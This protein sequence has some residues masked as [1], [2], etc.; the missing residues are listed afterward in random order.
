MAFSGGGDSVALLHLLRASGLRDLGAV[1]VHHGL[2]AVAD[3]WVRH[4]RKL[5]RAMDVPLRVLRV[6]VRPEGE[7][8]EAAARAARLAAFAALLKPGDVLATA[9]HRDDQAETILFRALRGT[10]IAGLGG[11]REC[12][13]LGQGTLWRPLL[14]VPRSQ[15]RAYAETQ[16][17]EWVDDPHNRDSRYA[18]AFLRQDVFPLLARHFPAAHDSLARLGRHAQ[19]A[20]GLLAQLAQEDAQRLEDRGGLTIPGLLRLDA[21]RRR[22]LLYH[23]WRAL[24]LQVPDADWFEKLERE[25]LAARPDADPA[26]AQGEG[27]ARRY[28][29]RLYLMR[30]LAPAPGRGT[31]K[32]WPRRKRSELP[33]GCGTLSCN[34]VPGTDVNVRFAVGGAHLRPA[35]SAHRRTLKNLCQEAGIPPWVRVRMPLVYRGAELIAAGGSW[36]S[37]TA[38]ELGLSFVWTHEL[39]GAAPNPLPGAVPGA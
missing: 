5:C 33:A 25:V 23:Q 10:G 34:R 16:R 12:E 29:D 22:N 28:R 36:R 37:D 21:E 31:I 35:G 2:Q 39:P 15:L 4:C 19:A 6:E 20:E 18:R 9:H 17:L 11:M 30:R 8:I 27:E 7:G 13:P 38:V 24:G 1:H 3:D 14:A 26:L 32:P